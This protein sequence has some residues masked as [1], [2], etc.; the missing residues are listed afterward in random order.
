MSGKRRRGVRAVQ[1]GTRHGRGNRR[2]DRIEYLPAPRPRARRGDARAAAARGPSPVGA[3]GSGG[4]RPAGSG[5]HPPARPWVRRAAASTRRSGRGCG[6]QW[7][8]PSGP[9]VG[10]AGSGERRRGPWARRV[11]PHDARRAGVEPADGVPAEYPRAAR[12]SL[13]DPAPL[14]PRSAREPG[15]LGAMSTPP[16]PHLSAVILAV[17]AKLRFFVKSRDPRFGELGV[18]SDG[19]SER[20]LY[21]A[22]AGGDR[23]AWTLD[24]GPDLDPH[25]LTRE[26]YDILS[27]GA[28]RDDGAIVYQDK[29]WRLRWR[30]SA[31]GM[32]A[33]AVSLAENA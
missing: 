11:A 33:Y 10:T 26:A 2:S 21:V 27:G 5:E 32:V 30:W 14:F 1:I 8:A 16:D 24:A 17:A 25:L 22:S 6:G 31:S 23:V 9:T 19:T 7:R 28:L 18:L 29:G 4:H 20:P 3:A 13:P 12:G 15:S